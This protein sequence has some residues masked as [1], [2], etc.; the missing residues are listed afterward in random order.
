[1]KVRRYKCQVP[2]TLSGLGKESENIV[3]EYCYITVAHNLTI[4]CYLVSDICDD[5][6]T[7]K[8]NEQLLNLLETKGIKLAQVLK[9]GLK[10]IEL[11]I[12]LDNIHKV[13]TEGQQYNID[14]MV[15]TPSIFGYVLYGLQTTPGL[16]R[17]NFKNRLVMSVSNKVLN[18]TLKKFWEL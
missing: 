4:R 16:N 8:P 2:H 1:M 14:G 18:E 3:N 10:Q 9:E 11:L 13:F 7:V 6:Y 12:G 17:G 15:C 5:I